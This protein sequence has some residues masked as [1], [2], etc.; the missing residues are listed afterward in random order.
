MMR[1]IML[2]TL[3]ALIS[4]ANGKPTIDST[5]HHQSWEAKTPKAKNGDV[6]D[7][8]IHKSREPA[9]TTN[10]DPR[11]SPL[12]WNVEPISEASSSALLQPPPGDPRYLFCSA[13]NVDITTADY[14]RLNQRQAIHTETVTDGT[15]TQTS[16]VI[17]EL[18]PGSSTFTNVFPDFPT[19]ID[20]ATVESTTMSQQTTSS[21]GPTTATSSTSNTSI[22]WRG[23]ATNITD[24]T[25]VPTPTDGPFGPS[26]FSHTTD[27]SVVVIQ[28]TV[29]IGPN[30]NA[31]ATSQAV[32]LRK[33]NETSKHLDIMIGILF[34]L[35]GMMVVG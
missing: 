11:T 1:F 35:V 26:A 29:T 28:T 18:S 19:S 24:N 3:R 14:A 34:C 16:T 31:T 20:S 30:P 32:G 17:T 6:V 33:R 4:F 22:M 10:P 8:L 12:T 21:T 25:G 7:E 15:I 2:L 13:C 9:I 5:K 27:I 23:G